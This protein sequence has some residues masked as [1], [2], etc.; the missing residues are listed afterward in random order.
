MVDKE[1]LYKYFTTMPNPIDDFEKVTSANVMDEDLRTT[2][3]F[4]TIQI[5]R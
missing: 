4:S 3:C 1:Y 5:P 2:V